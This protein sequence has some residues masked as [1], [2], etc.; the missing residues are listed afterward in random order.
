MLIWR[1]IE[2]FYNFLILGTPSKL[3]LI[4]AFFYLENYHMNSVNQ[5]E[6]R[7]NTTFVYKS[8]INYSHI[9]LNMM[10]SN[11]A[12]KWLRNIVVLLIIMAVVS[13]GISNRAS[14]IELLIAIMASKP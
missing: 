6:L 5:N 8:G 7:N 9:K 13:L 4:M 12:I 11:T 3:L 14:I 10:I 1:A 2:V